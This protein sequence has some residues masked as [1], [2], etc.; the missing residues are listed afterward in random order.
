M[1]HIDEFT[2]ARINEA[3]M[4]AQGLIDIPKRSNTKELAHA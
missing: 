4:I 2:M 1:A 3:I